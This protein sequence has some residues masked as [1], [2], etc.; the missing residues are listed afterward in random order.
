MKP[1]KR[2]A[3]VKWKASSSILLLFNFILKFPFCAIHTV[4]LIGIYVL[5][6]L[7]LIR[8]PLFLPAHTHSKKEQSIKIYWLVQSAFCLLPR[9]KVSNS[10]RASKRIKELRER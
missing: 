5:K 10:A 1:Q 7:H 3:D 6:M 9:G 8:S 2:H 4:I